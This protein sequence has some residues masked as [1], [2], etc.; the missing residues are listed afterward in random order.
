MSCRRDPDCV[1]AQ[2]GLKKLRAV[3]NGKERGNAAF[4]A[5]SYQ[6]AYDHYSASLAADPEL[7]T[8]FVAQVSDVPPLQQ[9]VSVLVECQVGAD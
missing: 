6:E 2:R 8:A 5:G 1:P 7:R 4:S 3:S 9:G